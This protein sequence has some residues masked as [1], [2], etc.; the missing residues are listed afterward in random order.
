MVGDSYSLLEA[1]YIEIN[2]DKKIGIGEAIRFSLAFPIFCVT[3]L[4]EYSK[5]PYIKDRFFDSIGRSKF[6]PLR[7]ILVDGSYIDSYKLMLEVLYCNNGNE[8]IDIDLEIRE[9]GLK[10]RS[11]FVDL[12]EKQK[13]IVVRFLEREVI[14]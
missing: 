8:K 2:K 12:S 4:I 1:S 14:K 3:R 13:D 7:P 6:H 10:S 5:D 9:I 11:E